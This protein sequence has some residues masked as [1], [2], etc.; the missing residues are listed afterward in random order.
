MRFFLIFLSFC[1]MKTFSNELLMVHISIEISKIYNYVGTIL[2][3]K[4]IS[5]IIKI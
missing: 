4:L 2:E 5:L 3:A 1:C